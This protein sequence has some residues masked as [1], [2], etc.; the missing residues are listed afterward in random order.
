MIEHEL[1]EYYVTQEFK[2]SKPLPKR[3]PLKHRK[4]MGITAG[5]FELKIDS[6]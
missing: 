3:G 4:S 6:R 2:K 5:G 1:I